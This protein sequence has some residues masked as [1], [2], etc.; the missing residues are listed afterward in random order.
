[1]S[2]ATGQINTG[3]RDSSSKVIETAARRTFPCMTETI[4]F[5]NDKSL[6][7]PRF[8]VMLLYLLNPGI[9]RTVFSLDSPARIRSLQ[10]PHPLQRFR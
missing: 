10:L 9:L 3:L 5:H 2:A 4:Q 1:V 7:N 6:V 8:S